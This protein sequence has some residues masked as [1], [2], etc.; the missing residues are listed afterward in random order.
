MH[1]I[2]TNMNDKGNQEIHDIPLD[3][4]QLLLKMAKLG[5]TSWI[6]GIGVYTG[7][8]CKIMKNAKVPVTK[9]SYI[10]L[11]MNKA[12]ICIF[13]LQAIFI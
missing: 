3:A 8:N 4:E 10:E 7:H 2:F 12:L 5:N 6:I 9:Y 1:L 13:I 11:L